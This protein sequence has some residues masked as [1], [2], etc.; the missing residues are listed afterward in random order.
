MRKII[1]EAREEVKRIRN[2]IK[3]AR[4]SIKTQKI[5]KN[6]NISKIIENIK[7]KSRRI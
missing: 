6:E 5:L 2:Q 4:E 3:Q 7:N 1:E